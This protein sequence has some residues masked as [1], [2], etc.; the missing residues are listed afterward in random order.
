MEHE[1]LILV[2]R[3]AVIRGGLHD[4]QVEHFDV[5][6]K[7]II[8]AIRILAAGE[9]ARVMLERDH[10][11]RKRLAV[12][13][14]RHLDAGILRERR[15]LRVIA[16]GQRRLLACHIRGIGS[17]AL[18]LPH[19]STKVIGRIIRRCIVVN[20]GILKGDLRLVDIDRG[21]HSLGL[22]RLDCAIRVSSAIFRRDGHGHL[23]GVIGRVFNCAIYTV[24]DIHI[25]S[26]FLANG[27]RGAK[28]FRRRYGAAVIDVRVLRSQLRSVDWNVHTRVIKVFDQ[29]PIFVV[30]A[31]CISII[32]RDVIAAEETRLR[33][34]RER[35]D[36][37]ASVEVAVLF[38]VVLLTSGLRD[39]VCIIVKAGHLHRL[40][41]HCR[42]QTGRRVIVFLPLEVTIL[43]VSF[44]CGNGHLPVDRCC[45]VVRDSILHIGLCPKIDTGRGNIVAD[46]L[47]DVVERISIARRQVIAITI[48]QARIYIPRGIHGCCIQVVGRD[49]VHEAIR[50]V[51]VV[52]VSGVFRKAF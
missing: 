7:L 43:I 6:I 34:D 45:E 37:T 33:L 38:G 18:V 15:R 39:E 49:Q 47:K 51:C 2:N 20:D 41:G 9:R 19:D 23:I 4:C 50:L 21:R 8:A 16:I 10:T 28:L 42:F 48:F 17:S 27:A 40:A 12:C 44:F 5:H 29:R 13:R 11:R 36:Q 14:D 46:F 22:L 35:H 52:P 25:V 1:G 26:H 3:L 30:N 24:V 32:R 31:G